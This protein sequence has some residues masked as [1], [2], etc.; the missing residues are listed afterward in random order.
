MIYRYLFSSLHFYFFFFTQKLFL[1]SYSG[2]FCTNM[3]LN[4]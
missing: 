4:I 2:V 1:V 3:K